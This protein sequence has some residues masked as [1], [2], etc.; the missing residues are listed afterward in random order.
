MG[1]IRPGYMGDIKIPGDAGHHLLVKAGRYCITGRQG[2]PT[3][4]L[5]DLV[6]V[7]HCSRGFRLIEAMRREA[8]LKSY[9]VNKRPLAP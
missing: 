1:K 4:S 2:Q 9:W 7:P 8:F 5:Q 6:R 3:I